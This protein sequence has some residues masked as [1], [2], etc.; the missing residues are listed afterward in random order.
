MLIFGKMFEHVFNLFR[1]VVRKNLNHVTLINTGIA[2]LELEPK[3]LSPLS[4]TQLLD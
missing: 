3:D 4:R 2:G 1:T